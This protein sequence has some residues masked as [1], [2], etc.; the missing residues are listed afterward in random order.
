MKNY[1]L[2]VQCPACECEFV[3]DISIFDQLVMTILDM[4]GMCF[5]VG[6]GCK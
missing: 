4:C 6:I 5:I 1:G 2:E 3:I